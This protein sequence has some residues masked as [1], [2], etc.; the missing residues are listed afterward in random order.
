M[1][2]ECLCC[3]QFDEN[4]MKNLWIHSQLTANAEIQKNKKKGNREQPSKKHSIVGNEM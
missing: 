1:P 4:Q 3:L 2:I